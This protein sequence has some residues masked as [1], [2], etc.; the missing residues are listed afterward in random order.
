MKISKKIIEKQILNHFEK[1]GIEEWLT[2]KRTDFE[3][4]SKITIDNKEYEIIIP[5]DIDVPGIYENE[6]ITVYDAFG[7]SF[8][9]EDGNLIIADVDRT[10]IDKQIEDIKEYEERK[11]Y[12]EAK[13]NEHE[14]F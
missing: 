7:N 12:K 6:W 5:Y 2:E 3:V 14:E 1:Y 11:E 9:V 10:S 13:M 4:C 8:C